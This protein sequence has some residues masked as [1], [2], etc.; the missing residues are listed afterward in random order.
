MN[1]T[2]RLLKLLSFDVRFLYYVNTI[3]FVSV[4]SSLFLDSLW[5]FFWQ[6]FK[7]ESPKGRRRLGVNKRTPARRQ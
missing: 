5:H 4:I 6:G 1:Q 2:H 3:N 7:D